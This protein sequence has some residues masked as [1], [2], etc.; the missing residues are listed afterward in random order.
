MNVDRTG[1][2]RAVVVENGVGETSK[3]GYPQF[4]VNAR[5]LELWDEDE[6]AWHPWEEYQ[7]DVDCYLILFGMVGK[8]KEFGTT[9]T[10]D[11]VCKVFDWNGNDFQ[12]LAADKAGIKFQVRI[13][14]NDPA[15]ADKTPFQVGWVDTYDAEPG[16]KIKKL[17][18][19]ELK[20]L[21]AK[22]AMLLKKKG[23]P[24]APV[25]AT[26]ANTAAQTATQ[27]V[28]AKKGKKQTEAVKT[29]APTVPPK[30]P[31]KAPP[32]VT[33]APPK[34]SGFPEG[35]CTKQEAWETCCAL[36]NDDCSD[37]QLGA[38]WHAAIAATA[39]DADEK[40]ITPEQW[41]VIKDAVLDDVGK[42]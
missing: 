11:Q 38:A 28:K 26:A 37:G 10:Y 2:F 39:P 8:K 7:Q 41:F 24:A 29:K 19:A 36:K 30:A 14:D 32:G 13:D 18:A 3:N 22:Y 17:D 31:P 27:A 20:T 9:L 12:D 5:L 40:D 33:K 25:S 16:R 34:A 21:N 1:T 42:F 35:K 15:Y 6:K 23:K 4:I